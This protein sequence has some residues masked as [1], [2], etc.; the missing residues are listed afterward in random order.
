[1]NILLTEERPRNHLALV[2]QK[3]LLNLLLP[4]RERYNDGLYV[5]PKGNPN[6]KVRIFTFIERHSSTVLLRA[7]ETDK[8]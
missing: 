3:D 1:M 2:L 7:V 5:D 8:M 4:C 6:T